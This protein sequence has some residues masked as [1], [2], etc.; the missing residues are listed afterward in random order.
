MIIIEV[1]YDYN[2]QAQTAYTKSISISFSLRTITKKIMV[3]IP[4]SRQGLQTT[5]A[6]LRI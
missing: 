1:H 6:T 5:F 3:Y 2:T 4:V